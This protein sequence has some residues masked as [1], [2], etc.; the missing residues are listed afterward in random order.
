MKTVFR[1]KCP[2]TSA[3]DI[4]G[5]KWSLVIIKQMLFEDK[6]TFKD[7]VASPE[8]IA[9]N[10]LSSRLKMLE[11]FN[12]VQKLKL[13]NNRKTNIYRLTEKGLS[14][15]P[16]LMELTLWS[17]DNIQDFHPNL[18]L[19]DQLETLRNN[20]EQAYQQIIDNYKIRM[21]KRY[22]NDN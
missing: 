3:L 17:K 16:V 9:T 2:I 19:N 11:A 7:F 21:K 1:S 18:N 8:S 4:V 22:A 6:Y 10:I 5:D 13:S 14:L 15:T 12:I 20:K